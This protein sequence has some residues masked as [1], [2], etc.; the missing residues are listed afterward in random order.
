MRLMVD[1]YGAIGLPRRGWRSKNRGTFRG[2]FPAIA[3]M[4]QDTKDS[5]SD[6]DGAAAVAPTRE[7]FAQVDQLLDLTAAERSCELERLASLQPA[8]HAQIRS[9]LQ[10]ADEAEALGFLESP[11]TLR[12]GQ[13]LGNYQVEVPLGEGGMG[14]VW[15]ARR[16]DG[17]YDAPVALKTLHAHL[18]R[19]AIR[20]RFVREGRILGALSH[21]GIARLMDAGIAEGG[22][23]YLVL[24]FID[25]ERIDTWCDARGLDLKE[26]VKLFLQV[27]G[28]VAYAHMHMVVHRDLKPSNILVTAS[29]E[30]KLLDFGIAK[31]IS[32][33]A[34]QSAAEMTRVG[35]RILT[36]DFAAPEQ[37]RGEPVTSAS[38]VY[39]LGVLLYRLLSGCKPYERAASAG[40]DFEHEIVHGIPVNP[41]RAT[42]PLDFELAGRATTPRELRRQLS[43]DLD[44][45]VCKALS[46]APAARYPTARALADDLERY[47]AHDPVE[48]RR[49]VRWYVLRR[50]V[51]RHWLPASAVTAV[52]LALLLGL[53]GIAWQARIARIEADKSQAVKNFLLS[54]FEQ[55]SA[56]NPDSEKARHTTAEQLLD[57]SGIKM[58][59]ALSDQ[60]EVRDELLM[61]LSDLYDQLELFKRGEPLARARLDDLLKAGR[62]PSTQ[63]ADARLRLGRI[64]L[65][66][67]RY[68]EGIAQL[69]ESLHVMDRIG[70]TRS[71]NRAQALLELGRG[72]YHALPLDDP[73]TSAHLEAAEQLYATYLPHEPD[74]YMA[75]QMLARVAER[76]G[77]F[78]EAEL[79]YKQF[80]ELASMPEFVSRAPGDAGRAS[81]D[82]GSFYLA[83]H[84][85]LEARPLLEQAVEIL[86][87]TQGTD[88][89]DTAD[90]KA[91]L[92]MA[93]VALNQPQQGEDL[94][95]QALRSAETSLGPDNLSSTVGIRQF[96]AGVQ[97]ARGEWRA[98]ADLLARNRAVIRADDE[99]DPEDCPFQCGS[100]LGASALLAA[101]QGDYKVAQRY[102]DISDAVIHRLHSERSEVYGRNQIVRAQLQAARGEA[103]AALV[104]LREVVAGWPASDEYL[105]NPN[106]LAQLQMIRVQ[107]QAGMDEAASTAATALL[108]RILALPEHEYFADW[109]AHVQRLL[110]VALTRRGRFAEAERALRRA[111]Q[112]REAMDVPTSPWLAEVRVSL[113]GELQSTGRP[114][115]ARLLLASARSAYASQ[116]AVGDARRRDIEQVS[117]RSHKPR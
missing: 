68:D 95:L 93:M 12:V 11:S 42:P 38:D 107:L 74:R 77:N 84:R 24:E 54:I 39:A 50:V 47:L 79:R 69:Q 88:S 101:D 37:L 2:H 5:I 117:E 80:L 9:I 15:R 62:K 63:L 97:R 75:V 96:A 14:E 41:S 53:A 46:K 6:A 34:T 89:M 43:G 8:L 49:G 111:L 3:T 20:E 100:T 90:A 58:L 31:L 22:E 105:P 18:A 60:P 7:L 92:G 109:E 65:M 40:V 26:R 104:A 33:D 102:L 70:E 66:Q 98:A 67:A 55:N 110:G 52:F 29:G 51:R 94:V 27:C 59:T 32:A 72:D 44:A 99:H 76:R 1:A 48:A 23:V 35:D 25:G 45:I 57:I 30:V 86:T 115:E 116:T 61:T 73:Q 4:P 36:P 108:G 71:P 82:L 85:Y 78:A 103:P 13:R 113:A 106:A 19:G 64:L 56:T 16:T 21:P 10:A 112:L 114:G 28:A 91:Y 81:D 17:A 83:Q 87:R